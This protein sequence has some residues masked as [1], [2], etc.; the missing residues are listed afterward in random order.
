MPTNAERGI[1]IT[2]GELASEGVDTVLDNLARAGANALTTSTHVTVE[3]PAGE[4]LREPPLDIA[5][6][7]R[8]LDRPLWGKRV[9]NVHR[10]SAH[11]ADPA[12]WKDLP[13]EPPPVA[14][15]EVRVD[16]ARQAIDGARECGLRTWVH[17]APY[18]LPGGTG[19]QDSTTFSTELR[20]EYRPRR[21]IGGSHP[22]AIAF[23]GCLNNPVVR[24]L[25][26]VRMREL[27]RHYGDAD[28]VELDWVEYP[29]YFIDKFF[30]CFCEHC[31]RQATEFG[32]DWQRITSSVR[33][34]WD[35]LHTLTNDQVLAM[36]ASGDWGEL[37]PD[38]AS[39]QQGLIDWLE[40]KSESVEFALADLRVTMDDA[41]A[42]HMA[43]A[44][45]G[46]ALPWGRMS[47]AAYASAEGVVDVQRVKLYSFH[48]LMMLR[49]WTDTILLWNRGSDVQPH[50]LTQAFLRFFD[51]EL[52]DP[53]PE[54][55]PE[56]FGMP[57]PDTSHNLTPGSYTHRL[58]N[59]L[60]RRENQAP[61]MPVVHAY[62]SAE[63]FAMVLDAVRPYTQ[64]GLWI[65]RYGYLSDEKLDVLRQ[66]WSG[67]S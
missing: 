36:T 54:L 44:A 4:G 47:G 21:F 41:G 28:G 43:I 2:T 61:I 15:E 63:D 11:P 52:V 25:G 65:Q 37:V 19:G 30:T 42:S 17:L 64:A 40:Y 23:T 55:M 46:F 9:V 33:V 14:P 34:L 8:I 18:V 59:A 38:P 45:G 39:M 66:E 67:I 51:L 12:L 53:P 16:F 32:Y 50:T 58:V 27:L 57:L 62:R 48:W 22:D 29:V 1:T 7:A 13:W 49:W 31:E 60:S 24:Q 3:A 26:R 20:D 35:S 10:Y 5:G 56:A 6:Q